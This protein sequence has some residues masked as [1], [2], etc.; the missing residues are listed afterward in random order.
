MS[1]PYRRPARPVTLTTRR[2]HRA[3]ASVAVLVAMLVGS[4]VRVVLQ[5]V[6]VALSTTLLV[7]ASRC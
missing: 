7:A 2:V 1:H 3:W 4:V 5:L 6:A